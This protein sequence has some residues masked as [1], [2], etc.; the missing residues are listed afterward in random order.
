L[1]LLYAGEMLRAGCHILGS[2]A[3]CL[4]AVW[5]AGVLGRA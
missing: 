5:A 2:V 4:L 3:L 1:E